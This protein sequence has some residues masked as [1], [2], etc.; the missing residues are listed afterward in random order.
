VKKD[1]EP[2]EPTAHTFVR[3]F[4]EH[5]VTM[6][7]RPAPY[8][9]PTNARWLPKMPKPMPEGMAEEY[10]DWMIESYRAVAKETGQPCLTAAEDKEKG[11]MEGWII[12]P[13]GQVDRV[14]GVLIA[15]VERPAGAAQTLELFTVYDKPSD[16]PNSYVVRRIKVTGGI[17]IP[18]EFPFMVT[19]NL[20]EI[21]AA[22][23]GWGAVN[24]GRKEGDD[25]VILE[26]WV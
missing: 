12:R 16:Y 13:S 19:S 23:R 2:E 21:R 22:L 25:P 17:A 9:N 4:G 7:I 3:R 11:T 20:E 8:I 26:V 1:S 15:Q 6:T 10:A 14:K 5:I 18:D 24:I